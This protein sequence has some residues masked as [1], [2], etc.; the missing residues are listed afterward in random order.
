MT[1]PT[2]LDRASDA[3]TMIA[4]A[5]AAR[6]RAHVRAMLFRLQSFGEQSVDRI[7]EAD[8]RKGEADE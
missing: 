7:G 5:H 3:E 4:E 8:D 2:L 6:V 1:D